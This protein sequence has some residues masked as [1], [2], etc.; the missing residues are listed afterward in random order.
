M[1]NPETPMSCEE[2]AEHLAGYLEHDLDEGMRARMELHSRGCTGC[3]VLL[4]DMRALSTSAAKLPPLAP[5]RDLWAGIAERIE[6][7]VVALNP[8]GETFAVRATRPRWRG[9]WMALAAAGLVAVTATVTYQVTTRSSARTQTVAV[10][11]AV[12]DAPL[13]P[14]AN[15]AAIE[16]TYNAEIARLREIVEQRS[17][18]LEPATVEV[19]QK[20]LKVIDDAIAQC[21][22]AL[23]SDPGSRFLIESLNDAL[24]SKVLL[25]RKAASLPTK[26]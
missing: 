19:L 17:T 9:A 2:F 25:L 24:E 20:N 6:T 16:Q 4:A 26:A 23:R 11:P 1:T 13:T 8:S 5:S 12:P 7:P 3:A 15:R 21:K 10:K 22:D 18:R 14:A